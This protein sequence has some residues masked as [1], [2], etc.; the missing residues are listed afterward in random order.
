MTGSHFNGLKSERSY[1]FTDNS[2]IVEVLEAAQNGASTALIIGSAG[3]NKIVMEAR[4]GSLRLEL[5]INGNK[6][7]EKV[8]AYLQPHTAGGGYG[9]RAQIIRSSLI[10][11]QME[12]T[13][14]R[15]II[16]RVDP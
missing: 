15:Y 4:S 12:L 14:H 2:V 7:G 9:M 3:S 13:G 16:Y 5:Y 8:L 11:R 1:N 6:V 10:P